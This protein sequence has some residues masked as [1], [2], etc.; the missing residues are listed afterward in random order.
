MSRHDVRVTAR[1]IDDELVDRISAMGL[2]VLGRRYI[3]R[4]RAERIAG[5]DEW[6]DAVVDYGEGLPLELWYE[7]ILA[8]LE[9][10]GDD[11]VLLWLIGD[12]PVDHL[13]GEDWDFLRRFEADGKTTPAVA[14][15][16]AAKSR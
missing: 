8:A 7:L 11:E 14:H 15:M 9:A 4:Q 16:L 10:A 3:D 2:G 6:I 13:V 12:R 5:D 1:Y